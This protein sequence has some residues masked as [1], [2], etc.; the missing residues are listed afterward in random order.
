MNIT[1]MRRDV[2]GFTRMAAVLQATLLAA[3]LF[4]HHHVA[5]QC[6][7]TDER[8]VLLVGDSWAFFMGVDQTINTVLERWGH[9]NAIFHTNLTLAENGA[10]TDDFL[11]AEKQAEIQAQIDANPSIKVVHLSIGGNDVLGDWHVS[12][13]QQ[14]TDSLRAAVAARL[15]QVI[16]FIKGTRPDIHIL[17]SGYVYPNFG[18]VIESIAPLQS[19]H[20]FYD[21]WADMGFPD[22]AQLNTILNEFSAS[23]EAYCATDPR[24]DFVPCTGLMQHTFGQDAPLGVPP[25][26]SYAPFVAPLPQG[27]IDYPSPQSSMRSYGIFLD[28][29]HLSAGGYR[30]MIDYHARKFYHKFLMHDHWALSEGGT[31][32]GSITSTGSVSNALTL[33]EQD[34]VRH[35]TMLS[36]NLDAVQ[37]NVTSAA[38]LFLRRSSLTG[39][40]PLEGAIRVAVKGT[41]GGSPELDALDYIDAAAAEEQACR[42]GD[43]DGNARWIRLDL[44][45]ALLPFITAGTVQFRITAPDALG[46]LVTFTDASDPELASV[47]DLTFGE[48]TTPVP[49]PQ[50]STDALRIYPNPTE[51]PLMIDARPGQIQSLELSDQ[52]GRIVWRSASFTSMDLSELPRGAYLLRIETTHGSTVERVV[53]W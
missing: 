24:V 30:D 29:F 49:D 19:I 41:F 1:R 34:G 13:T 22:F 9:S 7:E 21:T 35:A 18:E 15:L 12:F 40:N 53:K 48:L 11:G 42:F 46:G 36:F 10:E 37:G 2:P 45:E 31:H 14:Q 3:T 5:A 33:G 27:F 38:S 39:S 28:C 52:L 26:G 47:L 25:S 23:V 16:E 4:F 51:G 6:A 17:W 44:P 43:S 32:D 20:P 8:R 50:M